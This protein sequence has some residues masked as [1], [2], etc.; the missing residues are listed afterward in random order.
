MTRFGVAFIIL[1]VLHC[2]AQGAFQ[3]S[4]YVGDART[5]SLLDRIIHA[6]DLPASGISWLQDQGKGNYT[7]KFCTNVPIATEGSKSCTTVYETRVNN[8][9]SII[10]SAKN[11]D[12]VCFYAS[13]TGAVPDVLAPRQCEAPLT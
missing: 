10:A 12:L 9:S 1:T 4:L 8:W 11:V 7:L 2:F 6:A 13:L 3:A 5:T